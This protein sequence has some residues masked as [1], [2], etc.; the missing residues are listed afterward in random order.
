MPED[1]RRKLI[2]QYA[3][4]LK[5]LRSVRRAMSDY[6]AGQQFFD[7]Y[8]EPTED[9]ESEVPSESRRD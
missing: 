7:F 1:Q 8:P 3:R 6:F 9:Q 4:F 5:Q 2:R